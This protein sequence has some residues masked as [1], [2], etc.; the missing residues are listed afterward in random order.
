VGNR[1]H[2][3]NGEQTQLFSFRALRGSSNRC[4]KGFLDSARFQAGEHVL[5]VAEQ[6]SVSLPYSYLGF[7]AKMCR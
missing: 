4:S 5:G 3:R 2:N 1:N 6:P 7:V